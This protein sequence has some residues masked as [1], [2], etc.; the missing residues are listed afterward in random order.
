MLTKAALFD[1]KEILYKEEYWCV[2]Q[3]Y[4]FLFEDIIK[5]NL[6]MCGI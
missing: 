4:T 2:L 1:Q 6:I 3:F 5:S